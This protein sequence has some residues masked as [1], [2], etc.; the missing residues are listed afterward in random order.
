VPLQ[1]PAPASDAQPGQVVLL[2][3]RAKP[4]CWHDVD[5]GVPVHVGATRN[6]CGG[7]GRPSELFLQQICPVQSLSSLHDFAHVDA[8][9]PLQQSAAFAGQSC[10]VWHAFGHGSYAG[11]RHKPFAFKLGSIVFTDV[12]QTSPLFVAQSLLVAHAFGHSFA[13]TQIAWL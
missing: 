7:A 11:L 2:Q 8:H 3:P 4:H 6:S 9:T 10:E 5:T 1:E 13:A 12:Q